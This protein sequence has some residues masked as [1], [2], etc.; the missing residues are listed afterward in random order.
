MSGL[1]AWNPADEQPAPPAYAEETPLWHQVA[2]RERFRRT[3]LMHDSS[4]KRTDLVERTSKSLFPIIAWYRD[5]RA[6]IFAAKEGTLADTPASSI[7]LIAEYPI[8]Y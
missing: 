7:G 2:A 3:W 6:H 5:I 8:A 4:A 1:V